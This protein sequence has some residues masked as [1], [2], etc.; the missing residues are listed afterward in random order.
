MSYADIVATFSFIIACAAF[1][2]PYWRDYKAKKKE[3]RKD[4]L[5]IFTKNKWTNEGDITATPKAYYDLEIYKAGGLSNVY[6]IFHVNYDEQH[7]EFNGEI[8]AHGVLH[9]TLRIPIGK[10][11]ANIAKV[12]FIYL[13]DDGQIRYKFDGFVDN[14]DL[15]HAH[16]VLDAQELLWK[17]ETY[18]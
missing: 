9:T 6:G 10:V 13:E 16:D 14:K 17:L 8:D 11:G 5:E 3:R 1:F 12:R 2:L 7:Y 18:E 4:F 15:A